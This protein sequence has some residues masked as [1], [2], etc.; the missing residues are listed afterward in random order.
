M[1]CKH[2]VKSEEAYHI[3]ADGR[4]TPVE[5]LLCNWADSA[6]P[7]LVDVPRWMQR[8]AL[9]GYLWSEGDCD[10]CPCFASHPNGEQQ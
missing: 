10:R 9:A 5:V 3:W 4:E 7:Q 8:A 2:L 6:P 1:A